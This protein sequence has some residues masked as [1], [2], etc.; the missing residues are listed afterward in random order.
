MGE[1][2]AIPGEVVLW[3]P[4]G[5]VME[6]SISNVAFWRGGRWVTPDAAS[7]GLGGVV[8]RWMWERGAYVEGKVRKS[9]VES[10]EWV[11]LSSGVRGVFVGKVVL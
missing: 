10:G 11:L 2:Y 4:E 9:E 6:C 7:G 8:R 5:E 3:N 1:T